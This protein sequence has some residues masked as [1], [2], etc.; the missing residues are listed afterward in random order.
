MVGI[1]LVALCL[2]AVV[3]WLFR[4]VLHDS[5]TTVEQAVRAT[6][7]PCIAAGVAQGL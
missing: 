2:M 4:K 6:V 3:R 1:L 7:N 5:L